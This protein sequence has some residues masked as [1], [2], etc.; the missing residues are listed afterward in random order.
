MPPRLP[1]GTRKRGINPQ[2]RGIATTVQ[3]GAGDEN[4]AT[5]TEQEAIEEQLQRLGHARPISGIH[6][7]LKRNIYS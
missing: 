2:S 7:S 5:P 3:Y 1:P 4:Y 6:L